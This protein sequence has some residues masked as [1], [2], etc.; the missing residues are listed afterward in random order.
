MEDSHY[1]DFLVD[2]IN[3]YE[4][5]RREDQLAGTFHAAPAPPIWKGLESRDALDDCLGYA[6]RG[7][8]TGLSDVIT[9]SFQIFGSVYRP[10]DA[11]H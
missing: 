1:L 5:E 10:A 9:N 6:A 3:S 11:H 4:R 7:A 8:G 2:L